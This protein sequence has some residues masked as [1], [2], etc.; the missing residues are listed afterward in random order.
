MS[1][2]Q[3]ESLR[4]KFAKNH[5]KAAPRKLEAY[6]AKLVRETRDEPRLL[7]SRPPVLAEPDQTSLGPAEERVAAEE[8]SYTD[9]T[10]QAMQNEPEA[11]P[12]KVADRYA[13]EGRE[14]FTEHRANPRI[15]R[16]AGQQV[17][18]ATAEALRRGTDPT[19]Y[20]ERINVELDAMR[21]A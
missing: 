11:V 15:A 12:A 5:G 8:S 21:G 6:L 3:V 14:R 18:Q 1:K 2:G 7:R 19:P 20:L 10:F 9:S 17:R 4:V 16:S 13:E